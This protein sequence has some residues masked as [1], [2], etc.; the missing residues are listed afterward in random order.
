MLAEP[1]RRTQFLEEKLRLIA[2]LLPLNAPADRH[3]RHLCADVLKTREDA[4]A[5]NLDVPPTVVPMSVHGFR[6]LELEARL[7]LT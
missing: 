2:L 6:D 3:Q 1:T 4:S 7:E 5:K